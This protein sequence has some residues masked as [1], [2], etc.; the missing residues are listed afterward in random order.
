MEAINRYQY[1]EI[2]V[3]NLPIS[4]PNIFSEPQNTFLTAVKPTDLVISPSTPNVN[5]KMELI[6]NGETPRK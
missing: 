2:N 5:V 6:V 3:Y 1:P 4:T